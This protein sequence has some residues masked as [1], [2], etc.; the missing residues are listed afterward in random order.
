M[1]ES[2]EEVSRGS[3]ARGE[4]PLSDDSTLFLFRFFLSFVETVI[5]KSTGRE[6]EECQENR[7][8][9]NVRKGWRETVTTT[10][11][12]KGHQVSKSD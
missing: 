1:S 7:N 9:N 3:R 10:E 8:K 5:V 11:K 12:V 6:N 2:T 4:E